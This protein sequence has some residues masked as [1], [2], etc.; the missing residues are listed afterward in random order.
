MNKGFISVYLVLLAF[1]AQG[2]VRIDLDDRCKPG[3]PVLVGV[4]VGEKIFSRDTLT[5]GQ[6]SVDLSAGMYALV[7]S[8]VL[9]GDLLVVSDEQP[10]VKVYCDSISCSRSP[11]NEAFFRFVRSNDSIKKD[12]YASASGSAKSVLNWCYPQLEVAALPQKDLTNKRLNE[13]YLKT[14]VDSKSF[15]VNTPFFELNLDYYLS[16]LINQDPDTL[17]KYIRNMEAVLSGDVEDYFLRFVLHRYESSKLLG[18]ENVFIDVALRN[19]G[20]GRVLF[21]S[22]TDFNVL[23]KAKQL[24]PNRIGEQVSDFPMYSTQ[25][26]G[27]ENF[28]NSTG[29]YKLLVFFDPDCHHCKESFPDIVRFANTY[30]DAGVHVYAVSTGIDSDELQ[31]FI[32]EFGTSS[33]LHYRWDPNVSSKTF[34]DRYYIPSTPTIYLVSGSG[35]C[36]ARGIASSELNTLFSHIVNN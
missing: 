9:L 15:I 5:P 16:N 21:D 1:C 22:A 3:D 30:R 24:Y 34:R 4:R 23:N 7:R 29:V 27:A 8:G 36:L 28:I 35:R 2:Q 25:K 18:Q 10:L 31:R 11:V 17:I 33:N 14:L 12:V 13:L 19:L 20:N 6:N 26:S 32:S